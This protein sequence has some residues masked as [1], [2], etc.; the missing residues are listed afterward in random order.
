MERDGY[1]S[2]R[3]RLCVLDL[4]T[5]KK[6]YVTEKFE[7]GVNEFCWAP[8]SKDLYFTGV[9]HGKTQVYTTNL[10]GEHKALTDE[11]ADYALLGLA[12]DGAS[13]FVK[14]HSMSQADEVYRLSLKGK[15]KPAEQ[16]TFENQ[17]FYDKL[18]SARWKN[19]GSTR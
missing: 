3:T 17:Y 14:K 2:D 1:E 10:K 12:P 9:W 4:K 11:V 13:L 7:S 15:N 18:T 8:N 19:D 16:L 6:T 5:G